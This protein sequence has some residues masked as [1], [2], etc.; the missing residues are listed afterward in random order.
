MAWYFTVVI[1]VTLEFGFAW[2]ILANRKLRLLIY[3]KPQ[4]I[5]KNGNI[6]FKEMRKSRYNLD[7]L[8]L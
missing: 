6:L 1:L 8:I 5:I 3:G 4:V 7:D 2:L